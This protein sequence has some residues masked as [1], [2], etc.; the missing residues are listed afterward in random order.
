MKSQFRNT[1]VAFYFEKIKKPVFILK[2]MFAS[3]CRIR[4]KC[5]ICPIVGSTPRLPCLLTLPKTIMP[6]ETSFT[7]VIFTVFANPKN[8]LGSLN[9]EV[10][11]IQDAL[12]ETSGIKHVARIDTDT[13]AYFDFLQ[14]LEN[15]ICVFHYG[16]H[17]RDATL[18]LQNANTLFAPIADE[19]LARNHNSLVLVFLNGCS[20]HTHLHTLLASKLPIVIATSA[21]INDKMAMDF[22]VRFY[23]NFANGDTVLR[24]YESAYRYIATNNDYLKIFTYTPE[25]PHFLFSQMD[26][27]E[28]TE[29][30]FPWGLYVN[31]VAL[32]EEERKAVLNTTIQTL[33]SP[34]SSPDSLKAKFGVVG[35]TPSLPTAQPQE[36]KQSEEDLKKAL[37]KFNFSTQEQLVKTYLQQD[38]LAILGLKNTTKEEARLLFH[39]LTDRLLEQEKENVVLPVYTIS[40]KNLV[41]DN[42]LDFVDNCNS[43]RRKNVFFCLKVEAQVPPAFLQEILKYIKDN[44]TQPNNLCLVFLLADN[45]FLKEDIVVVP[46]SA[47]EVLEGQSDEALFAWLDKTQKDFL[48]WAQVYFPAMTTSPAICQ[49]YIAQFDSYETYNETDNRYAFHLLKHFMEKQGYALNIGENLQ[50]ELKTI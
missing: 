16:G 11:G 37:L 15:Q 34:K 44:Y 32:S 5:Y 43:A 27:V 39:L 10:N 46:P 12:I 24:A 21:V 48:D 30:V 31:D 40:A 2:K 45:K 8:D 42:I 33:R 9:A 28:D 18:S 14:R 25:P 4:T 6:F 38:K 3:I 7:P 17:S 19:L 49:E 23:Q 20:T 13:K 26:A 41:K 36:A 29:D 22:S 47:H 50:I 1:K 35:A